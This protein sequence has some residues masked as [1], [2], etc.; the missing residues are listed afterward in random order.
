MKKLFAFILTIVLFSC[1]DGDFDV[2]AFE[3]TDTVNSCGEYLLYKTSSENTEAIAINLSPT[4]LPTEVGEKEISLGSTK[5][6]TYRIFE[7]KIDKNYFC[8]SIPPLTPQILKELV[9]NGGTLLITTTAIENDGNVTGY[10]HALII[11]D[12]LFTDNNE[13]IFF[14]TFDFGQINID[15]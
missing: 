11:K 13:R 3:F 15:L 12:L 1:N 10:S 2:P 8:Q 6:V 5:S 7:D 9:A 4:D 14:E